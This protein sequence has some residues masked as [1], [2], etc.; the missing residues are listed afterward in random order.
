M[1]LRADEDGFVLTHTP[2]GALVRKD[3]KSLQTSATGNTHTSAAG[4]TTA[5]FTN[6]TFDGSTGST[7]Y[8]VG[9]LVK[10]CKAAGILA[11]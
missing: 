3:G 2:T 9:D 7:A 1:A 10:A 4:S 11:A 5:V 8:T 6:T